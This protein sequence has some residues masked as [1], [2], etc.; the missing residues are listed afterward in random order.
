[1]STLGM[2]FLMRNFI[3][4]TLCLAKRGWTV[5]DKRKDK[6]NYERVRERYIKEYAQVLSEKDLSQMRAMK[7]NYH[8]LVDYLVLEK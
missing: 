2:Y 3:L 5:R 6:V 7:S 1:M 8:G 4:Y